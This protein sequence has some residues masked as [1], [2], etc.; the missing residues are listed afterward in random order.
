MSF[1]EHFGDTDTVSSKR[2]LVA[3]SNGLIGGV[4]GDEALAVSSACFPDELATLGGFHVKT[5]TPIRGEVVAIEFC[6]SLGQR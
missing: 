1:L 2:H 5:Y 6:A 3:D 4:Y